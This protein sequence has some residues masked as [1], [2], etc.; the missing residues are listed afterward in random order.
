MSKGLDYF[1]SGA[2]DKSYVGALYTF[3]ET[4]NKITQADGSVWLK[5]GTGED[6]L[7][8]YPDAPKF[9]DSYVWSGTEVT[10]PAGSWVGVIYDETSYWTLNLSTKNVVE[11][12]TNLIPTG[13]EID[14]SA[15]MGGFGTGL[16]WDGTE[17]WICTRTFNK[18]YSYNSA[19][20]YQTEYTIN[21]EVI[22]DLTSVCWDSL[23]QKFWMVG[24]NRFIADMYA[25]S[26]DVTVGFPSHKAGQPY[27][28]EYDSDSD[29]LLMV[30]KTSPVEIYRYNK[31]GRLLN[32]YP[33]AGI[34]TL[35]D[36]TKSGDNIVVLSD[37][38][39]QLRLLNPVYKVGISEA[40]EEN[41]FIVYVRIK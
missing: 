30:D 24:T 25:T 16:G 23:E 5:T 15:K 18:M 28:I 4:D 3:N 19:W 8:S 39:D 11:L 27:G 36:L 13:V 12:D 31:Q 20:V 22:I 37:D 26:Q 38:S 14:V 32:I 33:V 9:V 7:A 21:N 40:L 29:T 10:L 17:A 1:L 34:G 41:G 2:A 6:D 35:I